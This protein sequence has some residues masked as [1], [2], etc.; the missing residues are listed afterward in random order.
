[1]NWIIGVIIIIVILM[2]FTLFAKK[3]QTQAQV[4]KKPCTGAFCTPR[5]SGDSCGFGSDADRPSDYDRPN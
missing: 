3:D 2:M 1:M 5:C 4:I